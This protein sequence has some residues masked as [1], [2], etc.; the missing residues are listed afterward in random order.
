MNT[1]VP[2]LRNRKRKDSTPIKGKIPTC[3]SSFE[4]AFLF[5]VVC[6]LFRFSLCLILGFL[7]NFFCV[8][9]FFVL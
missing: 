7:Q 9:V 5:V 8:F 4:Y 1:E 2:V 3:F 6:M